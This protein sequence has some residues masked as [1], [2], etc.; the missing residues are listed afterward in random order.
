MCVQTETQDPVTNEWKHAIIMYVNL[1][2]FFK[3]TNFMNSKF[4]DSITTVVIVTEFFLFYFKLSTE[5]NSYS[6]TVCTNIQYQ[7]P[8]A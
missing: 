8:T 3:F 1:R 5:Y 2:S 6:N 4:L 7:R